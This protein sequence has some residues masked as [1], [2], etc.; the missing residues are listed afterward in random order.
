MAEISRDEFE[1]WM[2]LLREDVQGVHR[3]LDTLNGRT[4]TAES[5]IAVLQDRSTEDRRSTAAVSGGIAV[6][7]AGV[8][9]GLRW[10]FSK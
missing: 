1:G 5:A 10:V 8:A 9:E 4:R 7:V 3:R 6:L 2:Q